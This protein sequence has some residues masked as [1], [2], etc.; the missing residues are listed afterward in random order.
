MILKVMRKILYISLIALLFSSC[1]DFLGTVPDTRA[2]LDSPESIRLLLVSAYPKFSYVPFTEMM[3]DNSGDKGSAIDEFSTNLSSGIIRMNQQAYRWDEMDGENQDTPDGYWGETYLAIATANQ[4]LDAIE[5]Y[6]AKGGRENL[7]PHRGEA[8]LCRAYAHF[9]LVNLWGEQYD[10]S[11]PDEL[12]VP[13]VVKPEKTLIVDYKRSTVS[14]VYRLIEQDLTEGLSLITDNYYKV[15]KFHFNRAAANAF[16]ARFYLY[17][18]EFSKA[19]EAANSALGVDAKEKIRDWNGSTYLPYS[20]EDVISIQ[21]GKALDQ[22]N[23]LINSCVS[24]WGRMFSFHYGT[25]YDILMQ[26]LGSTVAGTTS[27]SQLAFKNLSNSGFGVAWIYKYY[28]HFKRDGVNA[29]YGIAYV[30]YP[31]LTADEA[32]LNRAE[33]YLMLGTEDGKKKCLEDINTYYSKRIVSY[34][35]NKY[36]VTDAKIKA[37]YGSIEEGSLLFPEP[38]YPVTEE[39]VPYLSCLLDIRKLEFVHEG[40]RWFDIKRH[41]LGVEHKYTNGAIVTLGKNDPRRV[42]QI[43]TEAIKYG[44]EPNNRVVKPS[45]EIQDSKWEPI[46][47]L[48]PGDLVGGDKGGLVI[49]Q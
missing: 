13:Y 39:Q 47:V 5:E 2:E 36:A 38:F 8:L 14:E 25:T 31:V 32:L 41:H 35:A 19:I 20:D 49:K 42:L 44:I 6:K 27:T 43:P 45:S 29:N 9:M 23:L 30:M 17:K 22:S 48:K 21:Y 40:L 28:E 11:K 16:A 37:R 10:P 33:A 34:D 15:P 24:I 46:P 1:D 4:A 7:N 12:G 18:G 3:T 26:M